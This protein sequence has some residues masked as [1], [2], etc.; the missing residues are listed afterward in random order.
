ME[1][2]K[3][4]IF[5][6]IVAGLLAGGYYYY[7]HR[8]TKPAP[9]QGP[10]PVMTAKPETR[11]IVR[12]LQFTGQASAVE[13]VDIQARVAGYLQ[14]VA[15]KD[16]ATVRQ[17]DLLFEIEPDA[18]RAARDM[19]AAKVSSAEALLARAQ[20]DYERVQIAIK[21]NAVS[22]QEVGSR[23]ADVDVATAALDEAKAALVTSE[24][25]LSYTKIFA[26][27][28][29]RISRRLVDV[30]NLVGTPEKSLLANIVRMDPIY[31]YFYASEN[32]LVEQLAYHTSYVER[33]DDPLEV[34]LGNNSEYPYQ[35]K[36]DYM[37]NT[38]DPKTGTL[39]V[40]GL[41][42]NPN[43]QILPGMFVRIRVPTGDSN[44]VV[45]V[46]DKAVGTDLNG[47]FVYT[48]KADKTVEQRMIQIAETVGDMR[49][50]ESGLSG[51]ESYIITG[52][53]YVRPGMPVMEM[54]PGQNP[55]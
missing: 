8:K 36:L 39:Q 55:K 33:K 20:Q 48:V 54:T 1:R 14:K 53:Q 29:G 35:G 42:D 12:Y 25:N 10:T 27:I 51:D 11:T 16:G 52:T 32:Q 26:P 5:V 13:S 2:I 49:I 4:I 45:L 41:L 44:E 6:L 37:D 47:K 15:F 34:G 30:G 9:Q 31:V 21:D 7:N 43:V 23:K 3:Q 24:L 18:Y 46:Q 22:E 50:V 38:V 28:S 19:A 40:R 17:G